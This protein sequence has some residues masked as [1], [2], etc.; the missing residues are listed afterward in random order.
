MATLQILKKKL[1]SIRSIQKITKAMKTASSVK[2]SKLN[3]I[4]SNYSLYAK[5]YRSLC[6]DYSSYFDE[7]LSPRTSSAPCCYIVMASNKGMC[8]SFNNDIFSFALDEFS[9]CSERYV[10]ACGKQTQSFFD[11][12]N[13]SYD[14]LFS[15]SDVPTFD[16]SCE[17]FDEIIRL[18]KEGTVSS[19][20]IIYPKFKNMMVQTVVCEDLFNIEKSS[21][22]ENGD[23]FF[24]PDRETIVK[25]IAYKSY[26]AF[27]YEYL[28]E[29]AL[30]AQAATVMT[31][32]SA[33]DTAS[34]YCTALE[35]EI[36]RKRQSQV[37]A[38]VIETS[39]EQKD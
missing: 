24:L 39:A 22:K 10:I 13:I 12:K 18:R 29:T 23:V 8:G 17:L 28:L 36:N 33:F 20:K 32:R 21:E 7:V 6:D 31:M 16:E 4:Y 1:R 26:R 27:F 11:R 14:K 34:Q 35:S 19:V 38:D 2:Y 5:Q 37:T 9:N 25:E 3:V 15:F 30:G